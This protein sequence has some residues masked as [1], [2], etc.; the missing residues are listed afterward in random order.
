MQLPEYEVYAIKYGERM[1]TRGDMFMRGDLHDAPMAMDYFVWLIRDGERA[2]VVDVGFGQSE[3]E[4]RGRTFLRCPTEG[5]R[6]LGVEADAVEDV[7]ITH[8]HYDHAGNL[9]LFPNARFHIQDDELGYVTGRAM[10]HKVLRHSFRLAD[11]LEMVAMVY[12]DRVVFHDGDDDFAPG[13]S[14]H[15]FPGHA[16]GLQSVRVHTARGWI[17]LASDA[18]HYYESME[19]E[20]T[21]M[22]HENIFDMHESYRKL[23]RLGGSLSKIVPGHDPDVLARYPAPSPDLEGIVARLDVEPSR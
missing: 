5:L 20:P 9:E 19:K 3:G 7:I 17:V 15:H 8:M 6:L 10:T 18:A 22:T 21:F 13:I 16:R 2:I 12:G 23:V 4:K 14:L 1:G 11:V